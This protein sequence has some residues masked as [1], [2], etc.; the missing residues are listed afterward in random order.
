MFDNKSFINNENAIYNNTIG[1][2]IIHDDVKQKMKHQLKNQ[3]D[4]DVISSWYGKI[5]YI[6]KFGTALTS[7]RKGYIDISVRKD[8]KSLVEE[9]IP[10]THK[11]L[12]SIIWSRFGGMVYNQTTY[13]PDLEL[14]VNR[15]Q[16]R[17]GLKVDDYLRKNIEIDVDNYIKHLFYLESNVNVIRTKNKLQGEIYTTYNNYLLSD[18]LKKLTKGYSIYDR[19]I[20]NG[21]EIALTNSTSDTK[22]QQ[23]ANDDLINNIIYINSGTFIYDYDVIKL[24]N[25][26]RILVTDLIRNNNYFEDEYVY[27]VINRMNNGDYNIEIENENNYDNGIILAYIQFGFENKIRRIINISDNFKPLQLTKDINRLKEIDVQFENLL[28]EYESYLLEGGRNTYSFKFYMNFFIYKYNKYY[29]MHYQNRKHYK[30]NWFDIQKVFHWDNFHFDI[31][32]FELKYQ[33]EKIESKPK[34]KSINDKIYTINQY[35]LLDENSKVTIPS[36]YT[37]TKLIK[38]FLEDEKKLDIKY[39][40]FNKIPLIGGQHSPDSLKLLDIYLVDIK[41]LEH[42]YYDDFNLDNFRK[43]MSYSYPTLTNNNVIGYIDIEERDGF[44]F[45]ICNYGEQNIYN[46]SILELTTDSDYEDYKNINDDNKFFYQ[47]STYSYLINNPNISRYGHASFDKLISGGRTNLDNELNDS[48]ETYDDIINVWSTKQSM[49]ERENFEINDD[50]LFQTENDYRVYNYN[51]INDILTLAYNHQDQFSKNVAIQ[52]NHYS[53]IKVES[54][55]FQ[56][57][58]SVWYIDNGADK[59]CNISRIHTLF[60][61]LNIDDHLNYSR[62]VMFGNNEYFSLYI[63]NNKGNIYNFDIDLNI[64]T[65]ND[66][67]IDMIAINSAYTKFSTNEYYNHEYGN[68]HYRQEAL[69]TGGYNSEFELF[70]LY[71]F[72]MMKFNN[73]NVLPLATTGLSYGTTNESGWGQS[74]YI[75]LYSG[76][77]NS[78]ELNVSQV[79]KCGMSS[80]RIYELINNLDTQYLTFEKSFNLE[81]IIIKNRD[82]FGYLSYLF[83]SK[84]NLVT[85]YC[86]P[87]EQNNDINNQSEFYGYTY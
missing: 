62:G 67:S 43:A 75:E 68:E 26:L 22:E 10:F 44:I 87:K 77:H 55:D 50:Y 11:Y 71:S 1:N 78:S 35:N 83:R 37:I 53:T 3:S 48:I 52:G 40:S 9:P 61:N 42:E 54:N 85:S 79:I 2:K 59:Y 47:L 74:N 64:Y 16:K 81:N 73:K 30:K 38:E 51:R 86:N 29:W 12:K 39:N 72:F 45:N 46:D 5:A 7:I 65:L 25:P 82:Y 70:S 76:K 60:S 20:T 49:L 8:L 31:N 28:S 4:I 63:P 21:L 57:L 36:L 14:K 34:F 13:E 66:V 58:Y 15:F 17:Y 23:Y 56:N 69:I 41:N 18:S 33:Y 84:Y 19:I 32:W 24:K 27:L 80:E 6:N